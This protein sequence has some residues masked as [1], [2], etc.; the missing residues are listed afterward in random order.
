MNRKIH[1]PF[2]I[3]VE[4]K[5]KKYCWQC[6]TPLDVKTGLCPKCDKEKFKKKRKRKC[7]RAIVFV[8]LLIGIAIF[9]YVQKRGLPDFI[10]NLKSADIEKDIPDTDISGL[11]YYASPDENVRTDDGVT[12][13]DNEILVMLTS[14]EFEDDLETYLSIIGGKIVG[15]LEEVA[16][17]QIQLEQSCS[18]NEIE[19]ILAKL[20]E[21]DWVLYASANY[22]MK[23][24]TEYIPN[25]KKWEKQWDEFPSGE[26]WGMEA[27]DAPGAWD[28]KDQMGK[29]RIGIIDDMFDVNHEDL[30]FTEL[31]WGN[32]S[33]VEST[34]DKNGRE[35][36]SHG[37]H[38][39]GTVAATFD[40]KKGVTGV[41]V[42]TELYGVSI[43][44]IDENKTTAQAFNAALYYLIVKKECPVIN[45]SM[46]CDKLTFEASRY[47]AYAEKMLE[48]SS[49]EI[50][51]FLKCLIE[52]KYQ[53]VI[54]K[55]AGNQNDPNGGY[56]YFHKDADDNA[57]E[58]AYYSYNDLLEYTKEEKPGNNTEFE[59][60]KDRVEIIKTDA[61]NVDAKYDILGAITD[62]EVE[63]RIIMVGA[64][65]NLGVQKEGFWGKKEHKGY[66]IADFSQCG[67][68]V[69]ILAPGVDI[70]STV[71]KGYASMEGTSMAAPHVTGVCGLIFSVY[72]DIK[73]DKVK[74]IIKNSAEG[75]YGEEKYGL[76]NA[77]K[78]VE[79]T[80]M[81]KNV[82]TEKVEMPV[83]SSAAERDIVLV[84]DSSGSMEGTPI[85]ETKKASEGFIDAILK[86]EAN[87][88]IVTYSESAIRSS[89][90]LN[91]KGY[92]TGVV[93][94]IEAYGGTNIESGLSEAY[95]MLSESNAKKKIIVLMSDGEPNYGKEGGELIAYAD[96][97]KDDGIIIYTLGFFESMGSE[98][99]SAQ[100]LMEGIA[101]DGCHY[102]VA[103]ADDLVF[104]FGD[105]ADQIN[106]Q[107]YIYI[108]IAC[109]VDVS[110][111]YEGETLDSSEEAM[112]SRTDFG[113]L[114]FEEKEEE[115]WENENPEDRIKVLR[116]KEGAEYDLKITGT[117][118]G[119][120]NYTIGFMDDEGNYDDLRHFE[121][122]KI[123]KQT[124]IDTVAAPKEASV[125]K[126]DQDGD[127]RYDLKLKA[128]R[129]G[130]GK[131]VKI[132]YILYLAAGSG[133]LF[134][135]L[136][137]IIMCKIRKK[138]KKN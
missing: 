108:R 8:I 64:A 120:M 126:I 20:E 89:E 72:P 135:I 97:L 11:I 79:E 54:C 132:N 32:E 104:F 131:E 62:P 7:I 49:K 121:N 130:Y 109:P 82:E 66:K 63:K 13:V 75:S 31:P 1:C 71:K 26:N 16:E 6:G 85:E 84:L 45:I 74:D 123:T 47:V 112:C 88:G 65:E 69:D 58:Y 50:E 51:E 19:K 44:G 100:I 48:M 87:I 60:Y 41:S 40:N 81:L 9:G 2:A 37:T 27:I 29:V 119:F 83:S 80:I 42:N 5:M 94:D 137:F 116:L 39:S 106:G 73:A 90:F 68:Q 77:K 17:Y 53:F 98:K 96:S 36:S 46:A 12:Y 4:G 113:T 14:N 28:Y 122:V 124:I 21:Q 57:T 92:L 127:G 70:C 107:K 22:V 99:S 110:V 128:E 95:S 102:E 129:N 76:L 138:R 25:D 117:G 105:V 86:E 114:T 23:L 30:N 59:R 61:G 33:V 78:A 118:H 3:S 101:S 38:T 34:K 56:R 67:K 52:K 115:N 55:A 18:Y 134:V 133:V 43:Y 103:D 136:A 35:W 93:S 10:L 24:D 15:N 125:L 111:H 91:A